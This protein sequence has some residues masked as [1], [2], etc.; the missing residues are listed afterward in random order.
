[1]HCFPFFFFLESKESLE[2]EESL[3]DLEYPSFLFCLNDPFPSCMVSACALGSFMRAICMNFVCSCVRDSMNWANVGIFQFVPKRH[4]PEWKLDTYTVY[5]GPSLAKIVRISCLSCVDLS[6]P[7]YPKLNRK[8]LNLVKKSCILS[9]L[10][11]SKV[12]NSTSSI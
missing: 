3:K 8:Y 12:F 6:I 2:L 10:L 7:H 9:K 4:L 5:S 1:V 11:G